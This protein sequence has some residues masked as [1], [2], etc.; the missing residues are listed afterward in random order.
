VPRIIEMSAADWVALGPAA[1]PAPEVA[2]LGIVPSAAPP[3]V[4]SGAIAASSPDVV[5]RVVGERAIPE[6]V[7]RVLSDGERGLPRTLLALAPD[8]ARPTAAPSPRAPWFVRP[9][10]ARTFTPAE[11]RS[12]NAA[13]V[14]PFPD[15]AARRQMTRAERLAWGG[16]LAAMSPRRAEPRQE[17]ASPVSPELAPASRVPPGSPAAPVSPAPPGFPASPVP[18]PSAESPAE[19]PAPAEDPASLRAELAT[20]VGKAAAA[21]PLDLVDVVAYAW[22]AFRR[23][24]DP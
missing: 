11:L 24:R 12:V 23:G 16:A 22:R 17:P 15:V 10:Q 18:R 2:P 4:P 7:V 14:I 1:S 13:T 8:V 9:F 3:S 20:E 19:P 6:G 5:L 21:L